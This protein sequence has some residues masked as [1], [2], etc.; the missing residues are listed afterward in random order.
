MLLAIFSASAALVATPPFGTPMPYWT[1]ISHVCPEPR[2]NIVGESAYRFEE[3]SGPVFV[4]R[5]TSPLGNSG[6]L[7]CVLYLVCQQAPQLRYGR[8]E[9]LFELGCGV[10]GHTAARRALASGRARARLYMMSDLAD[11]RRVYGRREVTLELGEQLLL[12]L[13]HEV[14]AE[15]S[16]APRIYRVRKMSRPGAL[17]VTAQLGLLSSKVARNVK[18]EYGG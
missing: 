14:V 11:T 15:V 6:V 7:H 18:E 1:L 5:Q 16:S 17:H 13:L 2:C 10:V 3:R 12:L 9:R 8:R 4:D